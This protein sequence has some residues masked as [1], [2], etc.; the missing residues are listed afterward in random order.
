[1]DESKLQAIAEVR[2]LQAENK[3]LLEIKRI[4]QEN[5]INFYRPHAKQDKFHSA[6][7]NTGRYCRTGNRGGKT[8]CGAAEDVAFCLGYR[9]WYQYEFDV[10]GVRTN[11]ETGKREQY[12][13][14]RHEGGEGH[15]LVT[16]G[17]PQRPIKLLLIVVDWDKSKEIFTNN[18]GSYE[19]WG[20]L[21]QLIPKSAL[22]PKKG[23]GVHKSR[24][25][26]IDRIDLVRPDKYGGGVSSIYI[27]TV[28]SYKHSKMSAESSDWDVIHLDEPCPEGMFIAHSRGLVDRN[29]KFWINCTPLDQPWIN[30]E[31]TPPTKHSLKDAPEGLAFVKKMTNDQE[32]LRYVITW[33]IFDN[34]YNSDAAIAEF[35]SKL[36]TEQK[37]C[38]LYGL[39]LAMAGLVY[40]E[41]VWDEHVYTEIPKGWE[42][43]HRPPKDYTIRVWW[44]THIRLPQALLYFATAPDGRVFVYDEHFYENLIGPNAELLTEKTEGYFVCNKEIDPSALVDNPVDDTNIVDTLMDYGHYFQPA[45]KDR[46]RGTNMV[47]MKLKERGHDGK[48]TIMFSKNLT[49]TIWEFNHYIFDLET[50]KPKDKDDHQ[51]ENL[52]RAVLSGLEYITPPSDEDYAFRRQTTIGFNE[53]R[54]PVR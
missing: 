33:S 36:N 14:R 30:D 31:F 50:N 46:M 1:M 17:I 25:G 7:K 47:K 51:M 19:N 32:I 22:D 18:E 45:T 27:D 15:P 44:D 21:F 6:S 26:H 9:P 40:P 49:Q 10:M 16:Q 52:Y 38:R 35:E 41:F 13:V 24:G 42:D 8:K 37:A 54:I 43:F 39:P 2:R 11:A 5:G 12:V 34:P 23:G 3:R 29:G 48:P 53:S 28:E 20:D 4:R